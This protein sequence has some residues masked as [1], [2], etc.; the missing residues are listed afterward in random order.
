MDNRPTQPN[1]GVCRG[2]NMES[3]LYHKY[4]LDLCEWCILVVGSK[5]SHLASWCGWCEEKVLGSSLG[6]V[7]E[8][9]KAVDWLEMLT[10]LK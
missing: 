8:E 5:Y 10:K 1:V 6:H 3:V 4:K 2:C 7:C 9:G